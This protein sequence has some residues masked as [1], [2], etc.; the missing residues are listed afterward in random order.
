MKSHSHSYKLILPLYCAISINSAE[1]V[2][3]DR[4]A[5]ILVLATS[6]S[7]NDMPKFSSVWHC[8]QWKNSISVTWLL[9]EFSTTKKC[10]WWPWHSAS[11]RACD[12]W[13]LNL[14]EW[15]SISKKRYRKPL[16]WD[17]SYTLEQLM[18]PEKCMSGGR[19]EKRRAYLGFD[20]YLLLPLPAVKICC[21]WILAVWINDC[22][23]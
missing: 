10:L 21:Q 4:P 19:Q 7:C 3:Y 14:M 12:T 9:D 11:W 6:Q 2:M 17:P 16:L 1:P 23:K 5:K 13:L 8:R 20:A 15:D 22:S 18:T